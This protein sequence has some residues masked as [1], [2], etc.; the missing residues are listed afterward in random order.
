MLL[1]TNYKENNI[2][3]YTKYGNDFITY[4]NIHCDIISNPNHKTTL[5]QDECTIMQYIFIIYITN[6][7]RYEQL[8]ELF[9]FFIDNMHTNYY[10][11]INDETICYL[12]RCLIDKEILLLTDILY[13]KFINIINFIKNKDDTIISLLIRYVYKFFVFLNKPECLNYIKIN[14]HRN[15]YFDVYYL[16]HINKIIKVINNDLQY[17]NIWLDNHTSIRYKYISLS[18]L[19]LNDDNQLMCNKLLYKYN[20]FYTLKINNIYNAYNIQ[21]INKLKS[22]IANK[23]KL[24]KQIIYNL[25]TKYY[26]KIIEHSNNNDINNKNVNN[27]NYIITRIYI[28]IDAR[29]F[30]YVTENTLKQDLQIH[31]QKIFSLHNEFK[32]KYESHYKSVKDTQNSIYYSLNNKYNNLHNNI[33]KDNI[34]SQ[35]EFNTLNNN[36]NNIRFNYANLEKI[37]C[38]DRLITFYSN[39]NQTIELITN[40]LKN[41]NLYNEHIKYNYKFIIV[42]DLD[43]YDNL[44]KDDVINILKLNNI[45]LINIKNYKYKL[46]YLWLSLPRSFLITGEIYDDVQ[47]LDNNYYTKLF[48][49][50]SSIFKLNGLYYIPNISNNISTI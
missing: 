2:E 49:Y 50:L 47:F 32:N 41:N 28:L 30:F 46:L 6:N 3:E 29:Y 48:E 37:L 43:N 13:Y 7:C 5:T 31:N 12:L 15:L 45:E 27:D 17:D 9:S 39:I 1:L 38:N 26:T 34:L 21:Y 40:Q 20:I 22:L 19:F 42:N 35:S 24:D 4:Y 33:N 16:K 23:Y 44:I 10:Y 25:Y 14:K 11:I 36:N 8:S 18:L